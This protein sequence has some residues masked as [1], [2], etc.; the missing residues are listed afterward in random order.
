[1]DDLEKFF[2]RELRQSDKVNKL[3][4]GSEEYAP[5]KIFLRKS[6]HDFHFNNVAKTYVLVNEEEVARIWGYMSLMCSEITLDG[7]QRPSESESAQRYDTFPAVKIARLAIDKSLQSN[8]FGLAFIAQAIALVK[9]YIMPTVGCRF[10]TVDSKPKAI[11]FYEGAGF[12]LFDH[13]DNER[14]PNPLMLLDMHNYK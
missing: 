1:M 9:Y 11:K 3:S 10:L 6:A 2:I 14:N 4:L 7:H 12:V 5:L 13:K 8:G